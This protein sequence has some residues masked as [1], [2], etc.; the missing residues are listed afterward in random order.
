MWATPKPEYSVKGQGVIEH[1]ASSRQKQHNFVRK[2]V[3]MV[4]HVV[5]ENHVV[6]SN[7]LYIPAHSIIFHCAVNT[8]IEG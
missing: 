8:H 5:A 1:T 6:L 7:E 4:S 2:L 3:L